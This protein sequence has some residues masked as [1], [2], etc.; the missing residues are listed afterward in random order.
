MVPPLPTGDA[1]PFFFNRLLTSFKC[2]IWIAL[3]CMAEV[4]VVVG[5]FLP[6]DNTVLTF[7]R[8]S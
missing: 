5:V 7:F 3:A 8:S 2:I 4:P 6:L 1:Q